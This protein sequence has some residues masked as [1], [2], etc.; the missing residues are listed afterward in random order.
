MFLIQIFVSKNCFADNI[1]VFI[2]ES[3]FEFISPNI[4]LFS[5]QTDIRIICCNEIPQKSLTTGQPH[6]KSCSRPCLD[7]AFTLPYAFLDLAI[8]LP[9]Q[10]ATPVQGVVEG[11]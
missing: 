10:R 8:N 5:A 1:K 2:T 11:G 9:C 4:A 6:T 7:L 3:P